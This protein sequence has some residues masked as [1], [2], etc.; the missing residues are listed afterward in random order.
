MVYDRINAAF[1]G[2]VLGKKI[3]TV[4]RDPVDLD[5]NDKKK[6]DILRLSRPIYKYAIES[7]DITSVRLITTANN[8][9]K[10]EFNENPKLRLSIANIEDINQIV[11]VPSAKTVSQAIS[12][13][14]RSNGEELT[15]FFDM[16]KLT[17]EVI[18]LNIDSKKEL[19]AFINEQM[20]Y[21]GTLTQANEV[22][23]AACRASMKELGI[24]VNI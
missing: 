2:A 6:N 4:K 5:Y 24:D 19:E 13:F 14:E 23:A 17:R 10:V 20:K 16:E 11:P 8:E 15:I 9:K 7:H 22:E 1:C 12:K 18:A 21:L 3:C